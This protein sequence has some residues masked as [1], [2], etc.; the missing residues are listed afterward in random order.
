[1]QSVAAQDS[2]KMNNLISLPDKLFIALD[3]KTKNIEDKLSK[4]LRRYLNRLELQEQKLK[5]QLYRKDSSMAEEFFGDIDKRYDDLINNSGQASQFSQLYFGHFDSLSTALIFLKGQQGNYTAS[6]EQLKKL[7]THYKSLHSQFNIAEHVNKSLNQRQ[8]ILKDAFENLGMIKELKQFRKQVYYYQ[9][10]LKEYKDLFENPDKLEKKFLEL[11]ML[12]PKFKDFFARY[13]ILGTLFALPGNSIASN[14]SLVGLQ[15]RAALNQTIINQFGSGVNVTS[16][17]QQNVQSGQGQLGELQNKLISYSSDSYGNGNDVNMP[18]GF[19]PNEQKTKSFLQRIEY[20]V[21]IQSQK[22][23]YFFPVMADLGFSFGYKLN[24]KS[25]IGIGASYKL[26]LGRGWNNIAISQQGI[27]LRSYVDWKI[28][29]SF[30]ISGGYEQ[31]YMQM[32][33]SLSQ[34]KNISTWHRSGLLG[35]SKKYKFS[36]KMKGEMK[37]LWDFLSYHQM[38]RTQAILFRVGYSFN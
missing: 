18:E 9:A 25:S 36:G 14:I 11:V 28:K 31:N 8:T 5:K 13:S 34:I 1:M 12:H 7:I 10:Q 23:R 35:F 37:V 27:G 30:Y 15:T 3:K 17:L 32:I 29:G 33:K 20:S 26:G 21:N 16:Q 24:Q 22:A 19:K 38:P 6:N 4:Q 2:S